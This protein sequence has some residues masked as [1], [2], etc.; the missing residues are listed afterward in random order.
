MNKILSNLGLLSV[1]SFVCIPYILLWQPWNLIK[2][3]F[4]I[5]WKSRCDILVTFPY[6][7][8]KLLSILRS[9]LEKLNCVFYQSVH[10]WKNTK[11]QLFPSKFQCR[12]ITISKFY[13][14]VGVTVISWFL[15]HRIWKNYILYWDSNLKSKITFPVKILV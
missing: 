7:L 9:W 3:F 8:K 10:S 14:K 1:Y 2:C 13:E 11:K 15:Y 6:H 12:T 5:L 4:Q